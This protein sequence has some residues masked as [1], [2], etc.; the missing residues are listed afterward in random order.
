MEEIASGGAIYRPPVNYASSAAPA[1]AAEPAQP[2][3]FIAEIKKFS[4]QLD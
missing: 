4:R 3:L 1:A 2:Q